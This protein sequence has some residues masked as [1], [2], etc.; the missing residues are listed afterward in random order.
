MAQPM[1]VTT[2]LA[3]R[4]PAWAALAVAFAA[5]VAPCTAQS[6]CSPKNIL[7]LGNSL[8]YGQPAW[9]RMLTEQAGVPTTNLSDQIVGGNT[10]RQWLQAPAVLQNHIQGL[11]AG[12]SWDAVIVQ[13]YS[14][15]PTTTRGN[16]SAY[17]NDVVTLMQAV[18]AHSPHATG[19]LYQTAAYGFGHG[20]YPTWY[21]DP[22]AMDAD[23]RAGID[24]GLATL[25]AALGTDAG[26]VAPVGDAYRRDNFS[27]ILYRPDLMHGEHQGQLLSAMVLFREI[28]GRDVRS[29]SIQHGGAT[30][31][32][33]RLTATNIGP[34]RF[35]QLAARAD[36]AGH[37]LPG[38]RADL[39]LEHR[40]DT[41]P[42][43]TADRV[44][45]LP[46]QTLTTST[47][48]PRGGYATAPAFALLHVFATG[49][50]V[51]SIGIAELHIPPGPTT[52]FEL[53]GVP[54]AGGVGWSLSIPAVVPAGT[55]FRIQVAALRAAACAGNA[56]FTTTDAIEGT[57][58]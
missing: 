53:L 40:I 28:Y 34:A 20:Y 19:Y 8:S 46:L 31:L 15:E 22:Y 39:F 2:S 49:Q 3:I 45:V 48:S 51:P 57:V 30:T 11:P 4:R 43:R 1:P 24:L 37:Q 12:A 9:F 5:W 18:R 56:L 17:A 33:A 29:L 10:L 54:G 21:V 47:K 52:S 35:A 44:S 23:V 38:S 6:T 42:W 41:G 13:A 32:E 26:R 16:P 25:Q 27:P 58:Q 50:P 7:W 14:T 36:A 55:S